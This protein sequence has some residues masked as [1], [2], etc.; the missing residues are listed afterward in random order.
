[1]IKLIIAVLLATLIT[2]WVFEDDDAAAP[3][4]SRKE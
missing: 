3:D 2:T 1:M 4:Q